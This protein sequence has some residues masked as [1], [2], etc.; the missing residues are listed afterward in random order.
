MNILHNVSDIKNYIA[1]ALAFVTAI[2][3]CPP[4]A[5]AAT[6]FTQINLVTDDQAVNAAQFSDVNLKNAWGVAY[7]PT[8]PFWIS[9]NG[10][11]VSTIYNVN[12]STNA[13][14]KLGLT[15]SIPGNGNVTGQAFN[16]NSASFNGDIFLFVSED[17]TV[18]GWRG[19]L[20]TTAEVLATATPNNL[21]TGVTTASVNGSS[22]LY[23]ANFK[24]GAIDIMK[25]SPGAT[26]LNGSFT[27]PNL[28]S[29]YAPFN[30]QTLGDKLYVTY[31]LQD[32][33]SAD[34]VVGPGLG[35][36]SIFDFQ[37]N[38][39]ER[40]AS[41]GTLNVPWGL[42]IAPS[43]FGEFAGNLLVGN[44]G[45]GTINAYNL[46][47]HSYEGQLK[48]SNGQPL[49]IEGLWALMIGNGGQAGNSQA[50]YFTAGPN[51]EAHGLFG[52]IS[53]VPL[54]AAFWLFGS[55]LFGLILFGKRRLSQ[56]NLLKVLG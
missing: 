37:G 36:V 30:I 48:G 18:S 39:L 52:S 11:G 24:S 54:P 2:T 33:T 46:A 25:G 50:I 8:G 53:A 32:N 55:G 56:N 1:L 29:G 6:S 12:S 23:A 28:P 13:T 21:Y 51:N 41:Q 47:T 27:D 3:F 17:G 44:F 9:N 40:L 45:D 22:Y 20:G 31:A 38:F 14:S 42:A 4:T 5:L 49:S 19:A 26:D 10:S 35:L 16:G 43:S 15:V 34:E 7:S